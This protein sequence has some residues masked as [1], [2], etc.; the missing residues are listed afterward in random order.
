MDLLTLDDDAR[1]ALQRQGLSKRAL[2]AVELVIT[3]LDRSCESVVQ[4]TGED[5]FDDETSRGQLRWRR[6]RNRVEAVLSDE[7]VPVLAEVRADVSDNA[8]QVPVDGTRIS[9]YSARNGVERPDLSGGKK[10]KTAMVRAMQL[11]LRLGDVL[12]PSRLVVMYE[13]DEDGLVAVEAGFMRSTT[14]YAWSVPVYVRDEGLQTAR[15]AD[16]GP[17]HDELIEPAL[18]DLEDADHL[19]DHAELAEPTIPELEDR[20]DADEVHREG[21]ELGS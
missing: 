5:R 14:E 13:A 8:L 9:F 3:C 10:T 2:T 6:T 7:D 19:A 4:D 17:D 21:G 1:R 16:Q 15:A 11:Q 12:T 18:P 20:P